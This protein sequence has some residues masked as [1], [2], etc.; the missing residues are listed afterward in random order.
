[1][2]DYFNSEIKKRKTMSKKLTKH[3]SAFDRIGK[4]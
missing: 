4:T 2:K 3:I 1:M